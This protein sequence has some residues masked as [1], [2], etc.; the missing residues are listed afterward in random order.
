MIEG[1][2]CFRPPF[3]LNFDYHVVVFNVDAMLNSIE[4]NEI[5]NKKF[6]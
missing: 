3:L 4:Q 1:G 2:W 5:L 6:V